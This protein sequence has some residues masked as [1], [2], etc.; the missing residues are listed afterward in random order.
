MELVVKNW[1]EFQ[2]YKRRN[3]PWIRLYRKLLDDYDFAC[4]PDASRALA[5][6]LWLLASEHESG[7]IN[8]S[9]KALCFRL[10]TSEAR[11]ESALKPLLESGFFILCKQD[12]STLLAECKQD[13]TPE[14]ETETETE[15]E[16]GLRKPNSRALT[17]TNEI[18]EDFWKSY[19]RREGANPKH[20]ARKAFLAAVKAGTDPQA[21]MA[22]AKAYAADPSTQ[23][24]T[25]FVKQALVWLHQRCWEDFARGNVV[26]MPPP[27]LTE[28]Q[29]ADWKGGWRPGMPSSRELR[30]RHNNG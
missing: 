13:A 14:T 8:L 29:L 16:L 26:N 4:L 22:G 17:R 15:T 9:V 3:P 5:P 19:P 25:R 10:H 6:M 24:G 1:G 30:E 7:I 27:G 12:A 18:F 2:H 28:E 21:I 20:P 11:L 23:V